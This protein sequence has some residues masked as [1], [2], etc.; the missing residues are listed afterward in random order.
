MAAEPLIHWP[1]PLIELTGFLA[2]FLAAGALGFRFIVLRG[3]RR[4]ALAA[5]REVAARAQARAVVIG[6]VGALLAMV[7][8]APNLSASATRHH[9]TV[10]GLI[11]ASFQAQVQIAAR[12]IALA[13]FA[14]AAARR[15][16]G[17]WI[18]VVGVLGA[19]L[20]PLL[21]R[22]WT[23]LVN[24]IHALAAGMW[25]GT[26][27]VLLIAG[28]PALARAPIEPDRRAALT[29]AWVRAFS[30]L[31]L[32][33]AAVL[34]VFGV[35]TAWRHLKHWRA[36]W[37]TPYGIALLAKLCA[38][39]LVAAIGAWN[40]KRLS[41]RLGTEEGTRALARSARAE[42]LAAAGVLLNTAVLVSLPSP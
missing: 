13:G 30:P 17:W 11:A 31:A 38:V 26:L 39:M 15:S 6:L 29:A 22:Q 7:R 10:P 35:I 9:L 34:A 12:V 2:V 16:S 1:Q 28:L 8:Y 5:D 36:L 33:S 40:W 19:T 23:R 24:P 14:A 27:A 25:L 32:A 41:P 4:S 21:F 3:A 20:E 18:A 37:S 42:V